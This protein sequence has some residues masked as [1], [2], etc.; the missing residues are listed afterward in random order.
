MAKLATMKLE[1]YL[2]ANGKTPSAFAAE[3]GLPP[4]TIT[5]LLRGERSPGI[6]LIGKIIA[7]TKG[8]VQAADFLPTPTS[9]EERVA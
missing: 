3:A 2:T 4:S 8:D 6:E 9:Q 1:Q 7:A 5:R